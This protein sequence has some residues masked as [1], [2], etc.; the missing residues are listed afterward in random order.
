MGDFRRFCSEKVEKMAIF[1]NFVGI[2]VL[3]S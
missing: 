1:I 3:Q 2:I